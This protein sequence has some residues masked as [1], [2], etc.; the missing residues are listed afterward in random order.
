MA[1]WVGRRCPACHRTIKATELRYVGGWHFHKTPRAEHAIM[2]PVKS[3]VQNSAGRPERTR[4]RAYAR[5]SIRQTIRKG[6]GGRPE[7][8]I[9]S[10]VVAK[11]ARLYERHRRWTAVL[12]ELERTGNGAWARNTL[13]RRVTKYFVAQNS[14]S[15]SPAPRPP[16]AARAASKT[17]G[18]G[19]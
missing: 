4:V 2:D 14:A 11:A 16:R 10:L 7:V 17:R 9:P 3:T 6:F 13:I 15:S 19:A 12:E 1:G 5:P 8:L 18:G